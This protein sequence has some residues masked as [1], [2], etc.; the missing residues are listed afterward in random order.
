MARSAVFA[1]IASLAAT[2]IALLMGELLVRAVDRYVLFSLDLRRSVPQGE[3]QRVIGE[4]VLKHLNA[5][6]TAPSVQREWFFRDPPPPNPAA[7]RDPA[8]DARYWEHR[9]LELASIYVWNRRYVQE[10]VC[11]NQ[12]KFLGLRDAY[13]YVSPGGAQF[14][15]FRF[16]PNRVLPSGLVTNAFGWRGPAVELQKPPSTIRIAFVGASTTVNPHAFPFSYPEYIGGWLNAWATARKLTARFEIV[17]AGR[18]GTNSND[19]AAVVRDEIVPADPDLVVY[20]E[21]S[22]QFWPADFVEWPDGKL[23]DKPKIT[24]SLGWMERHSA[25]WRRVQFL[26]ASASGA[27]RRELPRTIGKLNWPADLNELDPDPNHPQ[28]PLN[29]GTILSDLD[30]IRS[31]LGDGGAELI[32]SSFVWLAYDGMVLDVTRQASLY[33]YLNETFWPFPYAHMRRMA[34]FQ[35]RVF[36]NYAFRH[37]VPYLDVAGKYPQDPSLFDDAVH[38]RQGGVRLHAWIAFNGL[39]PLLEERIRTGR[40]PRPAGE[41]RSVHPAFSTPPILLPIETLASR[42][43]GP[44]R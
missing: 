37:G 20:Y 4:V 31:A 43:A 24:F 15:R 11:R 19:F 42:C 3:E 35:N 27:L 41:T 1:V 28:L 5:I 34:D 36:R 16:L 21:G 6:A 18:E 13:V 23:P 29:L 14:P 30:V 40:L 25:V 39:V 12:G 2:L 32:L 9:G 44:A 38:M 17:N 8:L 33:R 7:I 10:E 26:A 22:N